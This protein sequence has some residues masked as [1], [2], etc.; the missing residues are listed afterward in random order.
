MTQ[1]VYDQSSCATRGV[2]FSSL[3][4]HQ[5]CPRDASVES[6]SDEHV[7]DGHVAEPRKRNQDA[8]GRGRVD[9]FG[10]RTLNDATRDSTK[11]HSCQRIKE[12]GPGVLK[13]MYLSIKKGVVRKRGNEP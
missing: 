9:G 11:L 4:K 3:K 8:R 7:N 6:E 13:E 12:T 2:P 10:E 1:I 5:N